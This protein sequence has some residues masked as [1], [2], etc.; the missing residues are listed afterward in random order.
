MAA[1]G[2]LMAVGGTE[3]IIKMFDLKKKKSCGELAG[4]HTSTITALAI[5]KKCNHLFSGSEDGVI[6]IWRVSD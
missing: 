2:N 6:A 5:S 4:V 1:E 3:E